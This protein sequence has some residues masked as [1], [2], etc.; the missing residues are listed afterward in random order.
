MKEMRIVY[1]PNPRITLEHARDVRARAWSFVFECY[2]D[3]KTVG[4]I[5]GGV[6]T[7]PERGF[8]TT[9]EVKPRTP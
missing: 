1:R 9:K 6:G 2:E 5:R 3:N 8:R 7:H 4:G